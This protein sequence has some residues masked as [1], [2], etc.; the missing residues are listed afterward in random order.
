VQAGHLEGVVSPGEI[1]HYVYCPRSWAVIA[2]ERLWSDNFHTAAGHLA[3]RRVEEGKGQ[4]GPSI[5]GVRV[6]SDEF[7]L[8]GVADRVDLTDEGPRPV[9]YKSARR[10][11]IDHRTQLAAQAICLEEMFGVSVDEGAVWLAKTRR[12]IPVRIASDEK[13]LALRTAD[14][15]RACRNEGSLPAPVNDE[16][17]SECSLKVYCLPAVVA[18]HRRIKNLHASLFKPPL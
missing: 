4:A 12:L 7:E 15:I 18:D 2:T 16:R 9:E 11:Q 6:W 14:S 3:H 5:F 17:C 13:D 8:Y 1:G 10:V